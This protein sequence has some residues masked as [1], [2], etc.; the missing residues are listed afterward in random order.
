MGDLVGG[1]SDAMHYRIYFLERTVFRHHRWQSIRDRNPPIR[2]GDA[3][4]LALF[5]ARIAHPV[6]NT[7]RGD[8]ESCS[9]SRIANPTL[10]RP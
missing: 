10:F 9:E 3:G 7:R 8:S 2:G 4:V 6:T 1:W 5:D